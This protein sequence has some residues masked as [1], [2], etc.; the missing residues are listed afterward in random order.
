MSSTVG[1]GVP[2]GPSRGNSTAAAA[3]ADATS[4]ELAL[5]N[6]WLLICAA[7]VFFQQCGFALLEAGSVRQKNVRWVGQAYA[8]L[9]HMV[10][11]CTI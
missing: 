7:L 3:T 4:L 2:A 10:R 11:S 9:A 5:T 6:F 1:S 8:V